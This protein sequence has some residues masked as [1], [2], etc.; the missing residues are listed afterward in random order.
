MLGN[1]H[2]IGRLEDF[3]AIAQFGANYVDCAYAVLRDGIDHEGNR[4]PRGFRF[5]SPDI[6]KEITQV[7]NY[8]AIGPDTKLAK[9]GRTTG[10]TT[11]IASGIS[12]DDVTVYLPGLGN[13]RFDNLLEI[14]WPSLE[15]PF[16]DLGDSGSMVFIPGALD[17]VGLLF[18]SGVLDIDG[19]EVGVSYACHLSTV[20]KSLELTLL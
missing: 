4:I 3:I 19:E 17:G 12:I 9:V 20:L 2:R 11:G 15:K 5:R 18:A 14:R 16:S 1:P 7:R 13:V 8:D 10:Y 6:G